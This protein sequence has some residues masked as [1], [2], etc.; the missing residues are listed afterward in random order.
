[1]VK[2]TCETSNNFF[3]LSLFLAVAIICLP[4]IIKIE[5][6]IETIVIQYFFKEI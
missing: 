6:G 2:G 4:T 5:F 3:V 1:M